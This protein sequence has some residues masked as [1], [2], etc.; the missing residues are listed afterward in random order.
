MREEAAEARVT[1]RLATQ[2]ALD[3]L[4]EC[5]DAPLI[6]SE[7]DTDTPPAKK[8]VAS[9]IPQPFARPAKRGEAYGGAYVTPE[10][11]QDALDPIARLE[12][13]RGVECTGA[14]Y[15]ECGW[16]AGTGPEVANTKSGFYHSLSD[17]RKFHVPWPN[18]TIYRSN[19]R[20]ALYD[21]LTFPEFIIIYY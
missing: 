6:Y 5:I 11:V 20:R 13:W 14:A 21:S 9:F 3:E 1:D 19:G 8:A 16:S 12:R 15:H 4:A 7:E 2:K 10:S 17:N 18:E